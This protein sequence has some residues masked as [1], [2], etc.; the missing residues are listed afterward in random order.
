MKQSRHPGHECFGWSSGFDGETNYVSSD[1]E[2]C[3]DFIYQLRAGNV[4]HFEAIETSDVDASEISEDEVLTDK[5]TE[6]E[7]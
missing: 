5:E 7:D 3:L 2:I 4:A 1:K 6:S